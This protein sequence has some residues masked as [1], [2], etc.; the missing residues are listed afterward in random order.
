LADDHEAH[1]HSAGGGCGSGDSQQR[2][3]LLAKIKDGKKLEV[4]AE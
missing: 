2:D 4:K 3:E 1:D